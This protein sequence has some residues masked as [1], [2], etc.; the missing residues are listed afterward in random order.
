MNQFESVLEVREFLSEHVQTVFFTNFE[1]QV[2]GQPVSDLEPLESLF[3]Q[4]EGLTLHMRALKYDEKAA[5]AHVKKITEVLQNPQILVSQTEKQQHEEVQ[6][7]VKEGEKPLTAHEQKM[8]KTYDQFF[9][10]LKAE[11]ESHQEQD[12]LNLDS[13]SLKDIPSHSIEKEMSK[14]KHVKCLDYLQVSAFNPVPA[15]RKL[16]GDLL[17]LTV[18]TLN[19]QE[20][21]ITCSPG[22]FFKNDSNERSHFSPEPSKRQNPCFSYTLVGTLARLSQEFGSNLETYINSLLQAEPYFLV[23]SP[24]ERYSWLVHNAQEELKTQNDGQTL[25]PLYGLDP[26]GVRDWNEEF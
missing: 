21:G 15:H 4:E 20:H 19:G 16:K 3:S 13:V 6:Q 14:V 8:K 25:Q 18:R 5:R 1:I 23:N 7:E 22:G 11:G 17:Y 12:S 2:R 26:K 24:H 9:E 10:A